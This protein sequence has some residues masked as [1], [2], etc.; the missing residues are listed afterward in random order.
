MVKL[1]LRSHRNRSRPQSDQ[2]RNPDAT[3]L[4]TSTVSTPP[5]VSS[6]S[7]NSSNDTSDDDDEIPRV[8]LPLAK[9]FPKAREV[10]RVLDSP[11]RALL[12]RSG[13]KNF[14]ILEEEL[15]SEFPMNVDQ[16]S[17]SWSVQRSQNV[18]WWLEHEAP[19]DIFPKILSYAGPRKVDSLSRVN[20]ALR[21][22]C[23]SG[24]VWK[25]LCEDTQKWIPGKDQDPFQDEER[26]DMDDDY[27]LRRLNFWK[28]YYCDN[29]I[30]PI[31]YS[32][33]P[34]AVNAV[35]DDN[36]DDTEELDSESATVHSRNV[37]VLI[38]PGNYTLTERV[39]VH[40]KGAA[41][42]TFETLE[43]PEQIVDQYNR[44]LQ[45]SSRTDITSRTSSNQRRRMTRSDIREF[46]T[47]RSNGNMSNQSLNFGL[48]RSML[49]NT[50][51]PMPMPTKATIEFKTRKMN[52]PIF[53][54]S[55]GSLQLSKLVLKHNCSGTDIWNGNTAVQS[56]PMFDDDDRPV[57]ASEPNTPPT[58][59]AEDCDIMS[60][61]GRGIV[62][63]DGGASFTRRCY[64]HHCAATGLYIG[65]PG[66]SASVESSDIVL[67]GNGNVRNRR[68]ITRGH[69]GVYLE[70]GEASLTD[71]NISNNS[72]TGIS[73]VSKQNAF[74]RLEG[75]DLIGNGT[76][77]LDMP[78]E[79]T[80]S[81]SR[82]FTKDNKM[83]ADGYARPRSGFMG[84]NDDTSTSESDQSRSTRRRTISI[85]SNESGM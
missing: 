30:V 7:S 81:R 65:G 61:S 40:V 29:P 46:L 62:A 39:H 69:S 73:A 43:Y 36:D 54:V 14:E 34:A 59:I 56:Q 68:G 37:R 84:E 2:T 83:A 9:K 53:H 18:L 27:E 47:C 15:D 58:V 63:I 21:A 5:P 35:A 23:L 76:V 49:N 26:G 48:S 50:E 24:D 10:L 8:C 32:T 60:I 33:I 42:I 82:S 75:S 79:G 17:L 1:W 19:S 25:T 52:E 11:R 66:S 77:Q 45:A 78:A 64:I 72:L 71:C 51:S 28:E 41:K 12:S 55:Q 13:K 6:L 57:R 74:L 85:S 3:S 16:N 67:N 70:Q 80:R 38:R 31:D 4:I 44:A 20:K 22:M